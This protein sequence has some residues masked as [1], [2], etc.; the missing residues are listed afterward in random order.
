[1][2]QCLMNSTQFQFLFMS[3]DYRIVY[4]IYKSRSKIKKYLNEEYHLL[5]CDAV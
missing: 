1:M 2:D 5:G 3:C 4:S